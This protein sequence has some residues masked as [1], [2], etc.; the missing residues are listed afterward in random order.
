MKWN[1]YIYDNYQQD[2]KDEIVNYTIDDLIKL[3]KSI[4][5][6]LSTN[7]FFF[8]FYFPFNGVSLFSG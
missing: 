3:K 5:A 4:A 8:I 7:D 1:I 6:L 2:L